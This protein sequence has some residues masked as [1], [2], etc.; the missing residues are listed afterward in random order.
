MPNLGSPEADPCLMPFKVTPKL[1]T[2]EVARDIAVLPTVSVTVSA[3]RAKNAS[4]KV[5]PWS[6]ATTSFCAGLVVPI[7]T[8]PEEV[9]AYVLC[10]LYF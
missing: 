9:S 2:G 4:E 6:V 7:P 8:L 5:V 10:L 3:F 1:L